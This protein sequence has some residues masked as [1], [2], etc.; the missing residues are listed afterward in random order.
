MG[1][2]NKM[3]EESECIEVIFKNYIENKNKKNLF[4]F[5]E[6]KDD[7]RYYSSRIFSYF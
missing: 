7:F 5:F 6:G 2:I 3:E 1:L 4:I